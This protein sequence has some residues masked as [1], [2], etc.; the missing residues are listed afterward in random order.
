MRIDHTNG[1]G[2]QKLYYWRHKKETN[3]LMVWHIHVE[4]SSNNDNQ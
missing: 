2:P 1:L 4:S 3:I